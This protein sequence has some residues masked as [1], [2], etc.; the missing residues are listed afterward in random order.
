MLSVAKRVEPTSSGIAGVKLVPLTSH[1]DH[2]G[3]FTEVFREE[4]ETGAA[5][6][7]WNV[8]R[9]KQ[10][11]LRGV[12][13]HVTHSDYLT[14]VDGAMVLGLRD[15]RPS[16]HTFGRVEHHQLVGQAMRAV[17]IPPG[18]AHGFCF[19][20]D[21]IHLYSVSHYWN[22]DD[23]LGCRWND[24]ALE[25]HWPVAEPQLSVRDSEAA[26]YAEMAETLAKRW[27]R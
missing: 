5:P 22:L 1:Q 12:H 13:V 2:R 20:S 3:V 10:G 18:V 14:V 7:Q 8:V 17:C 16:S 9:S 11:V 25:M 27:C 4:W 6:I 23:E 26:S 15:M 24:P 19:S 21:A